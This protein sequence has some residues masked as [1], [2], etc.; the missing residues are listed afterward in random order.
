MEGH[1]QGRE[2]LQCLDEGKIGLL[3]SMLKHEGEIPHRLV[4]VN[5]KQQGEWWAHLFLQ[6]MPDWRILNTQSDSLKLY[7][8]QVSKA[9]TEFSIFFVSWTWGREIV[10]PVKPGMDPGRFMRGKRVLI[11]N[12]SVLIE[13]GDKKT[14]RPCGRS[15]KK[16][17]QK[18]Y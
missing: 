11:I 6:K 15:D 1:P 16:G 9:T 17:G 18:L 2:V 12:T 14:D 7:S 4:V 8:L 5:S 3:I 10:S 13:I